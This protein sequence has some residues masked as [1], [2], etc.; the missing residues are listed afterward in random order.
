MTHEHTLELLDDFVDG[1]LDPRAERD[2]RRHLMQCDGCRAEER[3]LRTLLEH[4]A[5][6]D[7]EILPERELWAGIAPRL[8]VRSEGGV[9]GEREAADAETRVHER[10]RPRRLPWWMLAAASVALVATTAR[11]T[12]ELAPR[13]GLAELPVE[14][15]APPPAAATAFAAFRPSEREYE[16]AIGE[17]SAVLEARRE[18]LAPE[19]VAVVEA[20]L[21]VIDR[22]IA[23]SRA[24]LAADPA[25]G[26]LARMLADAYNAKLGVLHR[27]VQL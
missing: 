20:N 8:G 15:A 26:E 27:M 10:V 13:G 17:L 1:V 16:L 2:V 24:A 23:E 18:S 4:A 9:A 21:Q 22:A 6:L 11:V 5:R 14:R 19:T 3:A 12:L 25:S 7:A